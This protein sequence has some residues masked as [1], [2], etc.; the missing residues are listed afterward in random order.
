MAQDNWLDRLSALRNSIPD[1]ELEQKSDTNDTISETSVQQGRLDIIF[2]RKGRAGKCAT[3]ISGFTIP[4]DDIA[5]IASELKRRL[6]TGGSAR[7]GEILIQGDR[8]TD[9][10][11]FLKEKGIKARICQG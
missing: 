3:I 2:E 8:R 4:D 9:V 7:G 1:T 10:L 6:G 5:A 11:A